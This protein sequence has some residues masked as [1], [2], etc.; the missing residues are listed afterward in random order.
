MYIHQGPEQFEIHYIT[1]TP[2]QAVNNYTS[3]H[4]T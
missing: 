2:V 4:S 3:Q 1:Y